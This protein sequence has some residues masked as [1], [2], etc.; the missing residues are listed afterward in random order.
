M[1]IEAFVKSGLVQ[2]VFY[3]WMPMNVTFGDIAN[4]CSKDECMMNWWYQNLADGLE[5][6]PD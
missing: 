5:S 2:K 1:F 3:M 6:V 4:E